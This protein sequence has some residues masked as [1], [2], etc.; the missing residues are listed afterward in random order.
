MCKPRYFQR[1]QEGG[2]APGVFQYAGFWVRFG[3]KMIDGIIVGVANMVLGFMAGIMMA[4]DPTP[5]RIMALQL[6]LNVISLAINISYITFFLGR[7]GA[8]PGKMALGLKV[9]RPDGSPL[10]YG[11]A[12]GRGFAEI[13]SGIILLIGYIMAA[14]DDEKRTLH[15]RIADT[16][17]VKA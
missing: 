16:R 17:V 9:V 10:T 12:C 4:T 7:F 11:R 2:A 1:L 6:V 14:F 15:D 3:A 8:T 5:E 13:L